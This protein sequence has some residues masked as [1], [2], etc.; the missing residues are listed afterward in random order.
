LSHFASLVSVS[1]GPVED[2]KPTAASLDVM[3]PGGDGFSLCQ[4]WRAAGVTTPILFLTARDEVADRVRG[5]DRG[6]DDYLV[7][8]F[9]F[10]ELLAR[11]RAVLRR[12]GGAP[13]ND[14]LTCGDLAIDT[15]RRDFSQFVE[16]SSGSKKRSSAAAITNTLSRRSLGA[17]RYQ[18]TLCPKHWAGCGTSSTGMR[19]HDDSGSTARGERTAPS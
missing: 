18:P 4:R 3:L 6:G 16:T 17:S 10:A 15:R 13:V 5:L 1:N 14:V 11:L 19:F 2:E 7:K 8:P 9:A 12:R